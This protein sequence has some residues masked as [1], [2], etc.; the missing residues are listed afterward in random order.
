MFC[1]GRFLCPHRAVE[2]Y[3][4]IGAGS[5]PHTELLRNISRLGLSISGVGKASCATSEPVHVE[6]EHKQTINGCNV[7]FIP[8]GRPFMN[9]SHGPSSP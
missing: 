1:T 8:P 5:C 2:E 6:R 7:Y 3:L 9:P 4:K